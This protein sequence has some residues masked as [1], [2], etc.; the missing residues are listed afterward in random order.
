[1]N[2]YELSR[3]FTDFS[4]EN[5]SKVKPNHY[6]LYFF[7]IEHCN[8]L[9][10]KKEFG[11]PTT[12]TMEAIGIKSYNTYS[13]TFNELVEFG[14]FELVER[15][16]NQYSA[17]IIA[18]SNFNKALDKA[19]DKAFVKHDTKHC[20]ITQQSIDSIN[21]QI[22]SNQYTKEQVTRLKK[23]VD[24]FLGV[25]D[26]TRNEFEIKKEK[27]ILW[28]NQQKEIKTNKKGKVKVLSKTDDNNLKQLFKGYTIEDFQIAFDNMFK[29]DWAVNEGMTNPA[30]FLAIKNFN[31]YLSQ[32]VKA[33]KKKLNDLYD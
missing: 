16:K 6:A 26:E 11:L 27:F 33:P 30:H 5:P 13:N 31:K 24:K 19:L 17:N 23:C 29:S 10:W 12:M 22:T 15:S 18:L 3:K 8:R 4:F 25:E 32:G 7:A 1:M 2:S 14:F 28:F 9:G 21:K 20:S